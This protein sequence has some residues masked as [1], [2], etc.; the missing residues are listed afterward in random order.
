MRVSESLKFVF[1][2]VVAAGT[3]THY[4]V[5]QKVYGPLLQIGAMHW[6]R[7]PPDFRQ[8]L[9][10]AVVRNPYTR[11]KSVWWRTVGRGE[12]RRKY[13]PNLPRKMPFPDFVAWLTEKRRS[14]QLTQ[15]QAQWLRLIKR[16]VVILHLEKVEEEFKTLPF[17]QPGKPSHWPRLN[18][19]DKM[20][21]TKEVYTKEVADMVAK[22]AA[23]D[24]RKYGYDVDSWEGV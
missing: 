24:F 4:L 13:F 8:F 12:G 2:S 22:W 7:V 6:N 11:T 20:N 21:V 19:S 16:N 23:A 14:P 17:Y 1:V 10:W 5:V 18:S 3:H 9:I 15:T